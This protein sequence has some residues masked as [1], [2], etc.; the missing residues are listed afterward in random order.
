M[1]SLVDKTSEESIRK[2]LDVLPST[3]Y[4]TYGRA[5]QRIDNQEPNLRLLARKALVLL[6]HADEPMT[7]TELQHTLITSS[8]KESAH[9]GDI[10]IEDLVS[11]C[12]GLVFI[13]PE[14]QIVRLAH[15][16]TRQYIRQT[17]LSE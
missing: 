14:S 7:V 8:Q 5:M 2:A 11:L 4:D 10:E 17:L 13:E 3:L 12:A 16:T 9:I 6:A 1:D 15:Y